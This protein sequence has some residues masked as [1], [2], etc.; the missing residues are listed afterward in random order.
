MYCKFKDGFLLKS[1]QYTLVLF[2]LNTYVLSLHY[3]LQLAIRLY[4]LTQKY[5]FL[6]DLYFFLCM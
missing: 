3:F 6:I 2:Q 1:P 4:K 5:P